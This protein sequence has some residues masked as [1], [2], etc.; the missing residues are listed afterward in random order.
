MK[1]F[2]H[3]ALLSAVLAL[4]P[5][6][7]EGANSCD[8]FGNC[9]AYISQRPVPV[10]AQETSEWC[11][12][13][14]LSM[15]FAYYKHP[16]A[17][18]RIVERYYGLPLVVTGQ[19][20]VMDDAL[21]TSWVD[22]NGAPFNVASRITDYY[23]GTRIQVS[24]AD[25]IA[26]LISEN[27]VFYGDYTHAMVLVQAEYMNTIYGPYVTAGWVIDPWP[28][29]LG[30]R[31]L[32][33]TELAAQYLGIAKVTDLSS[34]QPV[35]TSVVNSASA[36]RSVTAQS[37]VTVYG[38]NL[39]TTTATWAAYIRNNV[40]PTSILGTSVTVGGKAAYLSY[41]SPTQ[42]NFIVPQ[43]STTGLV[44]VSITTPTG[45]T[46][47]TTTLQATSPGIFPIQW[48]SQTF[49]VATSGSTLLGPANA[50]PGV[51]RP[52]HRGETI[53]IWATGLGTTTPLPP[54]GRVIVPPYPAL[55]NPA[56][57]TVSFGGVTTHASYAGMT[58]A[59]AFQV[60]ATVPSNAPVG[61]I[62]V[63]V[64]VGSTLS[65]ANVLLAVGP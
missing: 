39:A 14:S 53:T 55:S 47:T 10:R 15:L 22:D 32:G 13:A 33:P 62:A 17:Q 64:Q 63:T 4:G 60:N 30:F 29:T 34:T 26:A 11:W 25:V 28:A 45:S 19:P 49:A 35:I 51:T 1:S 2:R 5:S 31:Q 38:K 41:V 42:L 44:P 3:F 58:F 40:L 50:I 16:V 43:V 21:N 54:D 6:G 18:D 36:D 56:A 48:G 61:N 65:A 46:A 27:P 12:A 59:G 23:Q 8:F 7:I 57:V 37:F 52:A 20:L 24:N 9:L